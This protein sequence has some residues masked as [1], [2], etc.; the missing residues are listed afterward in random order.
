MQS[1]FPPSHNSVKPPANGARPRRGSNSVPFQITEA[2]RAL[3]AF[4]QHLVN[5]SAARTAPDS[6]GGA[7]RTLCASEEYSNNGAHPRPGSKSVALRISGAALALFARSQP[8]KSRVSVRPG[9]R[10]AL[11]AFAQAFRLTVVLTC[12]IAVCATLGATDWLTFGGDAQRS[13]AALL[14]TKLTK[15]NVKSLSVQWKIKL[16]AAPKELNSLTAPVIVESV[17]T[18]KGVKD[19]LIVAAGADSVYAID[20]D[21][22]TVIW[23]RTFSPEGSPKQPPSWL[24]A[25]ALNATPVIEKIPKVKEKQVYVVSSDGKLHGLRIIDGEAVFPPVPFVPPYSKP[26]SLNLVGSTLYAPISQTC[27]GAKSAVYSIDVKDPKHPV[28]FFASTTTGG[29][30]IWGRAGVAVD[31]KGFVYA[32]TGDGPW[33]PASGKF[34]DTVLKLSPQDLKLADYY[35][36]SNREWLSRK[37]L[38]MGSMSPVVFRHG[39][40]ELVAA[41]G[42]EGAIYLLDTASMGGANHRSP[43]YKSPRYVNDDVDFAGRG[44]WGAFATYQDSKGERWLYAPAWGPVASGAPAFEKSHGPAPNG[45]IMAF[46]VESRDGKPTLIPAWVS[47]D[48]AVPEPPI[49][50]NGIVFALSN[51]ENARQQN[52]AG[53]LMSSTERAKTAPGRAVLYAFDA[54]TGQELYSSGESMGSFAHFGGI[55]LC[56]GR[57]YITTFDSTVYKFGLKEE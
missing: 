30:G 27:N 50:A 1:W 20:A 15:E 4:K 26:W 5:R 13:G 37:D 19:I 51:G 31:S 43:A 42:K 44:F 39:D 9:A 6:H 14:E 8:G 22:G 10:R 2:A 55:A 12:V 18:P 25:N 38:D 16:D 56:W 32:E 36:P 17:F 29:A 7:H 48:M 23:K 47:R 11:C 24:C 33:D 45:S 34:S 54:A 57:I 35:T 49:V 3:F 53:R 41:S 40:K 52:D 28:S 21:L 46:R